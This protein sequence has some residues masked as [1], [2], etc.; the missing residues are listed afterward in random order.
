MT[1]ESK[2]WTEKASMWQ[3][4]KEENRK[5]EDGPM[6]EGRKTKRTEADYLGGEIVC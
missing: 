5:G 2:L 1:K 6:S 3:M 4:E